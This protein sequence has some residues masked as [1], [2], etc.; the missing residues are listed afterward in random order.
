MT[1]WT[2]AHQAPLPVKFSRQEYWCGLPSH[3]PG[4]LP[5]PGIQPGSPA[6]PALQ[7]DG[8]FTAEPP[9]T[10]LCPYIWIEMLTI[11]SLHEFNPTG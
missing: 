3:Y 6:A 7:A 11:P 9:E 1:L 5:S 8:F 4:D 10:P 2:V